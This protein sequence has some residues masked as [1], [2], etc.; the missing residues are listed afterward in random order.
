MGKYIVLHTILFG[1]LVSGYLTGWIQAVVASDHIYATPL[2]GGL[3]GLGSLL[4]GFNRWE[5]TE[6]LA[7]KLPSVGLVATVMGLLI[8]VQSAVAMGGLVEN[9][10]QL[11][12]DMIGS[13][14]ANMAG[15][16]GY[17]WL[18]LLKRVCHEE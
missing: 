6:W 13:L 7:D 16:S 14:V 18:S 2:I 5:L 17:L 15:I 12:V 1:F 4:A 3:T 9:R 8:S 11:A 10:E